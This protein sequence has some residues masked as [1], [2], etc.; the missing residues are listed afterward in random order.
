MDPWI[1]VYIVAT[2]LI[3]PSVI[4]GIACQGNVNATFDKYSKVPCKSGITTGE[5]AQKLLENEGIKDVNVVK[6]N[7]KLSDCYAPRYK[8]VKLSE[9][10]YNSNSMAS[11]GVCA[12]EVGHAVQHAK[13]M[14]LFRLRSLFV[15]II[16]FANK[17]FVP[18]I[19]VGSILGFTFSILDVGFYIVLASVILYGLSLIFQLI[20]LPLEY[21]ASK[22]ALE[23]MK[24][25]NCFED[26]EL[27]D[28]KKVL[29][30]AIYTYVASFGTSLFYFLRFLSY[31]F[32]VAKTRDK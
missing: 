4:V 27:E 20:T 16:N 1:I 25:L 7:G 26:Y 10:T 24:K 32:V 31:A 15:P 3:L 29:K 8:V 11:L 2:V 12:H 5:L 18:L 21:N 9:S 17:L 22:R 14:F 23:M 13:G 6:I 28:A 30:A 19:L